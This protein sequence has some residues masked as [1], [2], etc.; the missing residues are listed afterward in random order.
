MNPVC[1]CKPVFLSIQA[2]MILTNKVAR[3][4]AFFYT[5]FLHVLILLMLI[6]LASAV[7][8]S[9]DMSSEWALK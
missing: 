7:D 5:I 1:I 9:R 8:C 6:K 3:T 4:I 2:K